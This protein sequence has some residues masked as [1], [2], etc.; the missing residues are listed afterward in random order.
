MYSLPC[1][2]AY[3]Y[4]T[5][6]IIFCSISLR[7]I[8]SKD[9]LKK[10]AHLLLHLNN[11]NAKFH[12][13]IIGIADKDLIQ[14]FTEILFNIHKGNI[15]LNGTQLKTIKKFSKAAKLILK[16]STGIESKK[17]LLQKGGFIP[18]LIAP[19]IGFLGSL[20]GNAIA[21]KR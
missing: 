17:R 13:K 1:A 20:I 3:I 11:C 7:E 4:I 14:L 6:D 5:V 15:P 16:R 21:K 18:A 19:I 10:N 8:M 12:R 2:R 9:L